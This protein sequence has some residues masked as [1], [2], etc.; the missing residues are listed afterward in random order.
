MK[1]MPELVEVITSVGFAGVIAFFC[2]HQLSKTDAVLEKNTQAI[3]E[4]VTLVKI[5]VE[6]KEEKKE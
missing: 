1:K 5:L 6:E 3:T 2:W 4:L